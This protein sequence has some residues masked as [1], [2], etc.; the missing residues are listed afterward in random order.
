MSEPSRGLPS[1]PAELYSAIIEQCAPED[2]QQSILALT[3]VLP[4]ASIPLYHLFQQITFKRSEQARYLTRRLL[5]PDGETVSLYV[6]ELSLD[7]WTVDAEVM[8]NL[9]RKLS[10]LRSLSLCIGTNFAPEHLKVIF[11]RC[12]FI[13]V[14][15]PGPH[16]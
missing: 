15:L 14:F 7:E 8:V 12:V 1:L 16:N 13:G 2:L 10:K 4:S 5:K 6:Q 9:L 11:E 3:R